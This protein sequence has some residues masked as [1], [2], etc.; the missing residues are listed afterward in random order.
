M[1]LLQGGFSLFAEP[2]SKRGPGVIKGCIRL[3]RGCLR[4]GNDF[5]EVRASIG[6]VC[7]WPS[8]KFVVKRVLKNLRH[9]V[10]PEPKNLSASKIR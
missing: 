4:Y 6:N 9:S 3:L 5:P 1:T 8:A 7:Q 2:G 10:A